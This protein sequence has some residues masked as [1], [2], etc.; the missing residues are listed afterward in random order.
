MAGCATDFGRHCQ[1]KNKQ[2]AQDIFIQF[3]NRC[4][5]YVNRS[6]LITLLEYNFPIS[7]KIKQRIT[8]T[9]CNN[10]HAIKTLV[11]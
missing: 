6:I 11:E 4:F 10:K 2:M 8:N 7:D 9:P 5:F 3:L 1:K